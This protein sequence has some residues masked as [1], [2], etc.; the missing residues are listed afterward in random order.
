[1]D[2]DG[3]ITDEFIAK[4]DSWYKCRFGR[5]DIDDLT[6]DE[7]QECYDFINKYE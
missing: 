2:K 6:K 3:K 5:K 1:M 4:F 7:L